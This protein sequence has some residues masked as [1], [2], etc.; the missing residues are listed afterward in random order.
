MT[1]ITAAGR[2]EVLKLAIVWGEDDSAQ[3]NE[4][5][6]ASTAVRDR[7]AAMLEMVKMMKAAGMDV[8]KFVTQFPALGE[9]P[10]R[11][12][13]MGRAALRA[14]LKERGVSYSGSDSVAVLRA[15]AR[16]SGHH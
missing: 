9:G 10:E 6:E 8:S 3:T 16:S 5:A 14:L 2:Q 1:R 15:R 11:Y 12:D 4:A 7:D 13:S